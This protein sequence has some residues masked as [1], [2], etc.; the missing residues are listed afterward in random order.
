MNLA[1][2]LMY[3]LTTLVSPTPLRSATDSNQQSSLLS[4]RSSSMYEQSIQFLRRSVV[5]HTPQPEKSEKSKKPKSTKDRSAKTGLKP[6]PIHSEIN[7]LRAVSPMPNGRASPAGSGVSEEP[8]MTTKN[9][10]RDSK[11]A[12]SAAQSSE[13][14]LFEDCAATLRKILKAD[15]VTLVDLADYALYVRRS[16]DAPKLKQDKQTKETILASFLSGK[17]WPTEYE[18]IVHY[19]PK[20]SEP[21]LKVLG[22]DAESEMTSH[23]NRPGSEDVMRDFV[24]HWTQ[25]RHFWWDREDQED[26]LSVRLMQ[27]MPEAALTTLATTFI[28][29]DGR[30]R[31]A[32]FACWKKAPSSFGDSQMAGLPFTWIVC[33]CAMAALSVRTT[34]ALGQSQISY[35]NLQAHELR[36]PLHQILAVTQLLRSAMNDLADTPQQRT[37]DGGCQTTMEQIRDLLP[38]LD[39]IDTSGKTL[40]GI[41]DNILSFLD[42]KGKDSMTSSNAPSLLNSPTGATQTLEIMFEELIH[43]AFEEDK[44]ARLANGQPSS[45]VETVLEIL[46]DGLGEDVIEDSGGALRRALGKIFS[47]AYKFIDGE[48]C[49]EIVVEDAEND[50]APEGFEDV[51][52]LQPEQIFC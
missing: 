35:S 8:V 29:Y 50:T 39:A 34:R 37:Y 38:L 19:I 17:P 47:N 30:P 10:P 36:T 46:T 6:R 43:E 48:G 42:L 11:R 12:K 16:A 52:R 44:R 40:H 1:N 22:A 25:T 2:M 21:G 15:S 9:G 20:T 26:E 32:M 4:K 45:H 24:Q 18:P 33:G 14:A 7:G 23:F 5:P 49:V 3:Q 51:G 31:F 28:T 27:C 13:R 41:V